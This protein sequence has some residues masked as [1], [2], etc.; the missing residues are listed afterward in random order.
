[1]RIARSCLV[2]VALALVASPAAGQAPVNN[3][4]DITVAR[5]VD[6][7]SDGNAAANYATGTTLLQTDNGVCNDVACCCTLNKSGAT[8]TFGTTGDGLDVLTSEAELTSVFNVA[9]HHTKVVTSASNCCGVTGGILGCAKTTSRN[10]VMVIGAP[11]DVWA[12]EFGHTKGLAHNNTCAQLIMHAT[13]L[14]TNAVTSAE[15]TSFRA[16]PDRT[17]G[18]C[19]TVPVLVQDLEVEARDSGVRL[20]WRIA[21]EALSEVFNVSVQRADG[22]EGPYADL[23]VL[24]PET[25]MRF[26][27][28]LVEPGK[29]Y[30]YRLALRE[31]TGTFFAGP[32]RADVPSGS[33][34][35]TAL[36]TPFE[37]HAG[38]SVE[39][40]YT[41]AA[42][43]PV[44]LAVYTVGGHLLRSFDQG[45]RDP[46][47]HVRTWDRTDDAGARLARGVYLVKLEAGEVTQAKKLVL[48]RD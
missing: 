20:A 7:A 40:R 5:H 28:R 44:R 47:T 29:S 36:A 11:G 26:E 24:A 33:G 31:E 1:M 43:T 46:G 17:S 34:L 41:V 15:C 30:W 9:T 38:G 18:T 6:A 39:M 22:V 42:R 14:N 35:R 13:N 23:R 45:V 3:V 25:A 16:N 27:D 32:I 10:I 12:H 48:V 4:F 21:P 2:L 8:G 19:G 37:H